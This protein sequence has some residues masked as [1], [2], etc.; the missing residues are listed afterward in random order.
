M[1]VVIFLMVLFITQTFRQERLIESAQQMAQADP[2]QGRCVTGLSSC[3]VHPAAFR[4]AMH[5]LRTCLHGFVMLHQCTNMIW[6]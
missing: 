5:C 6:H 4:A 2:E 1:Q 3:E